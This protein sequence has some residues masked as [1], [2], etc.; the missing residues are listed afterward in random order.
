MPNAPLAASL[1]YILE[2]FDVVLP[3]AI[4]GIR[5]ENNTQLLKCCQQ[6]RAL[7]EAYSDIALKAR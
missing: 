4:V 3:R 1:L 5:T 7:F 6:F 2:F